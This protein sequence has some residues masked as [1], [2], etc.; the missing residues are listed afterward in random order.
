MKS[1]ARTTWAAGVVLLG[2]GLAGCMLG[3]PVSPAPPIDPA[4]A[5]PPAVSA[6]PAF[7]PLTPQALAAHVQTLASDAFEGRKPGAPSEKLTLDYI[8][9]QF[10]AAG[11]KP[12]YDGQWLQP[13]AMLESKVVGQPVL[14]IPGPN[15]EPMGLMYGFDQVV[16]TKRQD[17]GASAALADAPLVFVGYGVNAP[18]VGWNDYAGVDMA[19]KVALILINDPDFEADLGD[20][21]GGKAMTYYGR[22]TY[23]L[24]EAARQG[25]AGALIIHETGPAAYPWAVVYSSW[26]GAQLDLVRE[27]KGM[28]RAAVEGWISRDGAERLFQ[29]EGLTYLGAKALAKTRG[30][31]PIAL[32][33]KA[34]INFQVETK[35]ST[36][37]N[38][39]GV[40][41][42]R[43]R[44]QEAVIYGAHWDHL[45][46]CPPV[47]GDDICNGARDN[48]VG[49]AG[50][51]E[52]ARRFGADGRPERS[53]AF[54]AFTAEEQ[55]LLG[56]AAYVE[57]P[58]FD[59]A[60]TA[61]MIN[62]DAPPVN[63][64]TR[65]MTIVGLGKSA[66]DARLKA[67]ARSQGRG[68]EAEA[69]PERGGFYRSDHFNFA[70]KG[71]PVLYAAGGVD[72]VRGGVAEGKRLQDVYV[73]SAYHK[74]DDEYDAATFDLT[75][76][77][78]DLT[79]LYMVGRQLADSRDW[80]EWAPS[81]EFRAEREK[82]RPVR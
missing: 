36:S 34:S 2:L 44:P 28:G 71:V 52:I 75:G 39:V 32:K 1:L 19:G 24:E 40:L 9:N 72:L 6:A 74:P 64:P 25:A 23:K 13:V 35:R 67:I 3:P 7:A 46:R 17:G 12:G 42:G 68:V 69:F 73:D 15:G 30:F 63:G 38:V 4:A 43:Q 61:A 80:P 53:V 29:R 79:A 20:A 57:R 45:G 59:H 22:W 77:A 65:A 58:A 76:T 62:I 27:D 55:G 16:W 10:A 37:Y 8:I 81:A 21:F 5:P 26:T 51:I 82:S 50:L 56:S 47:A 31:R 70:K 60:R 18:E 48:A 41:P 49:I 78:Q 66:L 33:A 54:I 11:L 14:Q